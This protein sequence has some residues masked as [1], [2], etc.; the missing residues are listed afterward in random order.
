MA[1]VVEGF[2]VFSVSDLTLASFLA[3]FTGPDGPVDE[4]QY[5]GDG[6]RGV[7]T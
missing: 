6:G 3:S 4:R 5:A 2:S 1:A 7:V